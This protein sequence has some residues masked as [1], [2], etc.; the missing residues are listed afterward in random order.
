MGIDTHLLE[1]IQALRPVGRCMIL[2]DCTF[3]VPWARHDG[4]DLHRFVGVV[5]LQE[6]D[7][8]DLFGSPTIRADLQQPLSDDLR[9]HYDV[10]IDAGTMFC[11]FDVAAVWRN[12]LLMLKTGGTI[13]HID[14]LT[15]HIGRGYY[16]FQPALFRDLY[17]ANGFEILRV[18]V[19][20][21]GGPFKGIDPSHVFATA[22]GWSDTNAGLVAELPGEAVVLCIA[23]KV[24]PVPFANPMPEFFR[25]ESH[26]ATGRLTPAARPSVLARVKARLPGAAR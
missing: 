17:A 19:K 12:A 14:A 16:N 25:D 5:G 8:I 3:H 22:D 13:V 23:R 18:A 11:C 6:A 15:G 2:G 10:V 1:E 9:D 4:R 7:T 20:E 21:S 24:E 26:R